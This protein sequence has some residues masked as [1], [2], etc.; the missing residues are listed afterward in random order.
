MA[1]LD[2]IRGR[3]GNLRSWRK[4]DAVP[5]TDLFIRFHQI[6][7]ENTSALELIADMEDKLGGEFVFDRKYLTDNVQKIE[8]ILRR[9]AY[10]FNYITDNKYLEINAVIEDIA[11]EL[12]MELAGQIVIPKGKTIL[13]LG[14]I[15]E[16]MDDAVGNKA[17][18]LSK[19]VNMPQTDVP[20]GF[21]VS[22][23]GFRKYLAYNN[24]FDQLETLLQEGQ[25][26]ERS[27]E[28]VSHQI[29]LLILGG[30]I[31]PELRR[32]ILMAAEGVCED[33]P[34]ECFFSVRSSAV[35]E[36]GD[37]SFAGLHE[38]F[39]NVPFRELLSS[40][41]KVLASLYN[42]ASLEYRFTRQL[43]TT[44]MAMAVLYQLMVPSRVAGVVYTLDPNDPQQQVCMIAASWGLG[45]MV[46]EGLGPVDTFRVARRPPH[47]VLEE[48][49]GAKE[50][51]IVPL[52]TGPAREAP[53]E[54]R[55][56]P[57]LKPPEAATIVETALI[58]ERYFKRP[59]D[60][61]WCLDQ[62][63]RLWILQARPLG[64]E[65][66]QR[67]PQP[68]AEGIAEKNIR[69]CWKTKGSS[70]TG[71]SARARYGW[72]KIFKI[73]S[74]SP[75]GLSWCPAL[76]CP[77]WPRPFPAPARSL[78][79]WEVRSATWPPWRGSSGCLPSSTPVWPPRN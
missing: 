36:D 62:K 71:A 79:T 35:G 49:I 74:D 3:L 12:Q 24:L 16:V 8:D 25:R 77:G 52:E 5:F 73:W 55:Y 37:M 67:S 1:I 10:D 66:E 20:A 42:P 22:I 58:L 63:G 48:R 68:R 43:P 78:P 54:L 33:H 57:C 38:S 9:S 13:T 32:E 75:A 70:P 2:R 14:E 60:I 31:P 11:K 53:R 61:E 28:S 30:D 46:V 51:M 76:P 44:D 19:M 4:R 15:T 29:R 6:M 64:P 47:E 39:L 59:L 26:Q 23:G 34:E 41:K 56:K 50:Q 69:C 17:H 40:F 7:Q 65:R 18:N 72:P 27:L 45:K 21:V